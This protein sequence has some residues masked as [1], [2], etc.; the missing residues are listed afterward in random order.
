ML[1]GNPLMRMR[2]A[3]TS[4]PLAARLVPLIPIALGLVL[5]CEGQATS[6]VSERVP[7]NPAPTSTPRQP[8]TATP[9]P[10]STAVPRS[11]A[12]LTPSPTASSTTAPQPPGNPTAVI[13][14]LTTNSELVITVSTTPD[15]IPTYDRDDWR[16]WTDED[17]DCQNTR[18]EVLI[19]ESRAEVKYKDERECQVLIGEWYGAFTGTTVTEAADLDVDHLVPL[20]NA[21]QSG[22]WNWTAERKEEYANSLAEPVH[23]IAVTSSAN[24]SK[25]AKGPDQWRPPDESYWC[26]YA[27]AWITVKQNWELNATQPE[28]EA[29]EEMLGTCEGP[30]A[31]TVITS[32]PASV[33]TSSSPRPV[34]D[35]VYD[36]CDEAEEAG[37]QRLRGSKG[38]GRGFL[39][40]MVPSAGDGDGD[41]IVCEK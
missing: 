5:G 38:A 33:T 7:S 8:P 23:L 4:L 39:Q 24:R 1:F 32:D 19:Q 10:T 29:L 18:H 30:P 13:S 16:H 26:E 36:S 40:A 22:G 6:P 2:S 15:D 34:S 35:A 21:H 41:G 12:M 3:S 14:G 11:V 17:R 28:A 31:F 20:K 25:G 27:V 37:E 9:D